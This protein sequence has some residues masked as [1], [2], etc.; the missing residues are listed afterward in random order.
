M[1]IFLLTPIDA[2]SE[3]WQDS[4]HKGE[5]FVRAKD[6]RQARS[7]ANIHFYGA[8]TSMLPWRQPDLVTC[9]T[10]DDWDGET[11]GKLEVLYPVNHA[12]PDRPREA[13]HLRTLAYQA[14]HG[15]TDLRKLG[16]IIHNHLLDQEVMIATLKLSDGVAR[17]GDWV[18]EV[19][20][21]GEREHLPLI[22]SGLRKIADELER[23]AMQP[24]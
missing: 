17:I 16:E 7:L 19:K 23:Q 24:S 4:T 6:E 10:I 14:E 13:R 1:M 12:I 20:E 18:N 3:H 9:E 5:V 22:A 8:D 15:T 11:D 2:E 21:T